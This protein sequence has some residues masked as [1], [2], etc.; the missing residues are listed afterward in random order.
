MAIKT[1]LIEYD[2]TH[3]N[4]MGEFTLSAPAVEIVR[5]RDCKHVFDGA[6]DMPIHARQAADAPL[7]SLLKNALP[8]FYRDNAAINAL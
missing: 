5:C 3:G 2:D 4:G 8:V 6:R 7:T 1:L